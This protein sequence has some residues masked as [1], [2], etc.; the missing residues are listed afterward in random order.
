MSEQT[1]RKRG[2]FILFLALLGLPL[3]GDSAVKF[4]ERLMIYYPPNDHHF[5]TPESPLKPEEVYWTAQDGTRTHG[6]FGASR[7]GAGPCLLSWKCGQYC[8]Q[9]PLG[10]PADGGR[11]QCLDGRVPGV[12]DA[13]KE[14]LQKRVSTVTPMLSG[15]G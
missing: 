9:I 7:L 14:N 8:R 4:L 12:T 2:F 1:K 11:C 6:W 3:A 10:G 5:E 15:N 13:V